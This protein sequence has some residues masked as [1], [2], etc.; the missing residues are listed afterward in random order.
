MA[1]VIYIGNAQNVPD[2]W[3]LVVT[4]VGVG[5][6]LS[7]IINSKTITY[8]VVTGDTTTTAASALLALLQAQSAPPEFAELTWASSAATITG[9]GPLTGEPTVVTKSDGG[10]ATCTLTHTTTA[11]SQSDVSLAAN[12]LRGGTPGLPQAG[13][14]VVL[15]NNTVPLL[16]NLTALAAVAF[17]SFTRYQSQ[18]GQIG[19][20]S[21][22]PAGYYEYR[23][24]HFQFIGSGTLPVL[25]GVN[26][27]GSGPPLER[28]DQLTQVT[29]YTVLNSGS[30]SG[31]YAVELLTTGANS[32]LLVLGTTVGY[33]PYSG[34][35]GAVL[36]VVV[37][38]GGSVTLGPG[39]AVGTSVKVKNGTANL[40]CTAPL[41]ITNGSTVTVLQGGLTFTSIVASGGSTLTYLVGGTITALT[42]QTNSTLD[43][44]GSLAAMTITDSTIDGDTCQI[45]DPNNTIVFTNASVVNQ[46]V[47]SGPFVV[48]GGRTWKLT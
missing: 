45:L 16:W 34:E 25:L 40:Y 42:L 26:D 38:G 36:T 1:T 12:W 39:C 28:Y 9:T 44:S 29:A 10:G 32:T 30:P 47:T 18:T 8:T 27:S 7:V 13:D 3:T 21:W 11:T 33:A 2:L 43:K 24:T 31:P 15:Q 20:P 37:D 41:T 6:T 23:P 17:A 14:T 5:G 19:L 46:Q 48:G 22:N 4:G 35:T